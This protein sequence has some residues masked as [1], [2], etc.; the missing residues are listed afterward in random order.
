MS[1]NRQRGEKLMLIGTDEFLNIQIDKPIQLIAHKPTDDKLIGKNPTTIIVDEIQALIPNGIP[2][3]LSGPL[4][5]RGHESQMN[6][7][8]SIK[9]TKPQ[10]FRTTM[11]NRILYM[12]AKQQIFREYPAFMAGLVPWD[13]SMEITQHVV[14]AGSIDYGMVFMFHCFNI[15]LDDGELPG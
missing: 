4:Q 1:S 13:E 8:K 12:E 9:L 15:L 2:E 5:F 7:I 6:P 11:R 14:E 10:E 3:F